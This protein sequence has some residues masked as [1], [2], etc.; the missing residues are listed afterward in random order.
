MH[1]AVHRRGRGAIGAILGTCDASRVS[2]PTAR[3]HAI[4]AR[5]RGTLV[6]A[7]PPG[8]TTTPRPP[9]DACAARGW[10]GAG[11][12]GLA[13]TPVVDGWRRQLST[14]AAAN[15]VPHVTLTGP[16]AQVRMLIGAR[17]SPLPSTVR[18]VVSQ[19]YP[20]RLPS[21]A[22]NHRYRWGAGR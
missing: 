20:T 7:A 6:G 3:L 15:P 18:G 14:Q 22:E 2:R 12:G 4:G 13:V 10:A 1:R 19:S 17:V 21:L 9:C 5:S 8:P 16:C 11:R